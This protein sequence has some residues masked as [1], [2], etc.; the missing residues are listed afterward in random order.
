MAAAIASA[1][2]AG[3]TADGPDQKLR[4]KIREAFDLFDD[5]ADGTVGSA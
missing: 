1:A 4:N 5:N 3:L 2:G